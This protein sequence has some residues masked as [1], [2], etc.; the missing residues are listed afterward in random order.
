MC[1]WLPVQFTKY[2][3]CEDK[4]YKRLDSGGRMN[5]ITIA[6]TALA[7]GRTLITSDALQHAALIKAGGKARYVNPNEK[8]Y[9][10]E[11]D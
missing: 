11:D 1:C 4:K 9:R 3:L 2:Q 5:D 10:R 8:S 6:G 7:S